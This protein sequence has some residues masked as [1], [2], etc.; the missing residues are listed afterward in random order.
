M[1]IGGVHGSEAAGVQ[2][3]DML[4]DLLRNAS[5]PPAFSLIVVPA[6]F[7]EN[8]A[9]G[10]RKTSKKSV[11]PNRQM[12]AIGS[13]PGTQDSEGRPIEAENL[14]LLDL[15]ERFHPERIASV[16]GN[17]HANMASITSDP[18]PGNEA[19]D[20]DLALDMARQAKAGG[21]RVPGNKLGTKQ[22]S[23]TYPTST[24]PGGHE[25]GVTFGEYGSHQAGSRPAMNVIL[26]E[27]SGNATVEKTG[28]KRRAARKIELESFA[29]VLRDVFLKP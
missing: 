28:R 5:A 27:T 29:T 14:V 6:L 15:I 26:I 22:E 13:S 25:K 19:A 4:L 3:V 12:P 17:A 18:R 23:A 7:P 1:I 11:D 8:V 21:A 2:V 16:H 20:K 9:K 24:A 10:K